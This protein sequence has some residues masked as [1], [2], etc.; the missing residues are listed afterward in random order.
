[1]KWQSTFLLAQTKSG[2]C[3]DVAMKS[4]LNH[5]Y[6]KAIF[7]R[8]IDFVPQQANLTQMQRFGHMFGLQLKAYKVD[9]ISKTKSIKQP[10][11][12]L[13]QE[14]SMNHY[15]LVQWHDSITLKTNAFGETLYV[16]ANHFQKTFTGYLMHT[17]TFYKQKIHPKAFFQWN[18]KSANFVQGIQVIA[19]SVFSILV[20]LISVGLPLDIFTLVI[21]MMII[22]HLFYHSQWLMGLKQFDTSL[23][24]QFRLWI[25]DAKQYERFQHL[26]VVI[27][28][29]TLVLMQ[30]LFNAYLLWF[31]AWLMDERLAWILLLLIIPYAVL[32]AFILTWNQKKEQWLERQ[33]SN[34]L[35]GLI[36]VDDYVAFQRSSYHYLFWMQVLSLIKVIVIVLIAFIFLFLI[37]ALTIYALSIVVSILWFWGKNIDQWMQ[38]GPIEKKAKQSIYGFIIH[39]QP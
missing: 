18:M 15:Q 11:I 27:L 25:H 32:T 7:H 14:A 23:M 30:S 8:I 24:K 36:A 38:Y 5:C 1:M 13:T 31:Y 22:N 6:D 35:H 2:T 28:K 34:F 3:G 37:D 21:T 17:D 29:P 39:R 26:K 19:L 10:F 4:L 12:A 33:E 20:L 16:D 9:H